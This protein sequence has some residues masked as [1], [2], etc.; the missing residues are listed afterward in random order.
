MLRLREQ[1]TTY[2]VFVAK[3]FHGCVKA[4][5]PRPILCSRCL[6][7]GDIGVLSAVVKMQ[8]LRTLPRRDNGIGL[9]TGSSE[10]A[11]RALERAFEG[12]KVNKYSNLARIV[13]AEC[14]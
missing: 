10:A 6:P 5:L 7:A 9:A 3:P 14:A 11:E 1:R 2:S 13:K 12:I 4:A 8:P